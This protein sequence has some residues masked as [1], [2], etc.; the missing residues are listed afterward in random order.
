MNIRRFTPA[1]RIFHALLMLS[2][3]LQSATGLARFYSE[4]AWGN[5]LASL[6]GGQ[7]ANLAVHKA[8]GLFMIALFLLHLVSLAV[9][10]RKSYFYGPD[11]MV[12]RLRDVTDFFKHTGWIL[13]LC[14]HPRLER[15]SYWE[16]FDYWAVFWGVA[17]I[18]GSGLVLLDPVA[19]G[20]FMP[21]WYLN[22]AR[23]LHY[24]E[25]ILAMG[26]IFLVHFFV[27]H[28]RRSHFPM[29]LAMFSGGTDLEDLKRERG[30]WYDRLAAGGKLETMAVPKA[31]SGARVLFYLLG[32]SAVACGLYLLV[33]GLLNARHVTW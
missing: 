19:S 25:A 28:L 32:L 23:E 20:R 31:P 16:K 11:S 22:L 29:D 33:G 8:G 27:G 15:W 13:W 4:T 5:W 24:H 26:Y 14:P 1:Q 9:T 10:A 6:F 7:A 18:G 17:I 3:L 12:P 30:D 2:F 21:G